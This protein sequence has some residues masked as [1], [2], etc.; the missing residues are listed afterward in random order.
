MNHR[1]MLI[2]QVKEEYQNLSQMEYGVS[3][4]PYYEELLNQVM[5][6][7]GQGRFDGFRTGHEVVE[8]VANNKPGWDIQ[9]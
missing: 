5:K 6:G 3:A 7:I 1:Q 9:M 8:A 2:N 4:E